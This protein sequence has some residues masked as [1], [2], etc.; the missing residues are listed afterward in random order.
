MIIVEIVDRLFLVSGVV[1]LCLVT[2]GGGGSAPYSSPPRRLP[3]SQAQKALVNIYGTC[4]MTKTEKTQ[5]DEET[6]SLQL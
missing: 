4:T 6:V 5:I 2:S 3:R 1:S